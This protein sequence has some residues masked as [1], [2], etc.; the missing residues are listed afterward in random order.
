M[1][2]QALVLHFL[3]LP[4]NIP[5]CG[6]TTFYLLIHQ[7]MN[8]GL[9]PSFGS[10]E[11]C[12]FQHSCTRSCADVPLNFSWVAFLG[13]PVR[14]RLGCLTVKFTGQPAGPWFQ[15]CGQTSLSESVRVIQA[16][17]NI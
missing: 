8:I 13:C 10:Y 6:E 5:S 11:K 17:I 2:Q 12:R 1:L 3:L 16:E 15:T 4:S 7:L 9:F 14:L